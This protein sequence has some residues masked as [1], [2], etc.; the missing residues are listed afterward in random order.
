MFCK[1]GKLSMFPIEVKILIFDPGIQEKSISK[2][3]FPSL[4]LSEKKDICL[5]SHLLA[6][7][8]PKCINVFGVH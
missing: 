2:K 4:H 5:K 7:P 6:P 3:F 8:T 1:S